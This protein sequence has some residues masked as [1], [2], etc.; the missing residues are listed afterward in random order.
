MSVYSKYMAIMIVPGIQAGKEAQQGY[1]NVKNRSL[2]SSIVTVVA[3]V[4]AVAWIQSLAWELP[5]AV[6]MAKRIIR[7]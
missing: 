4:T 7:V 6:G 2:R 5:H 3:L 1:K